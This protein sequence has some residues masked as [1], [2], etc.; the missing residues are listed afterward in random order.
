MDE[1]MKSLESTSDRS[2]QDTP[3]TLTVEHS[4]LQFSAG[5]PSG[6]TN[7]DKHVATV[8]VV[9]GNV[10][11]PDAESA[12]DTESD[13]SEE[14]TSSSG[15]T[16]SAD[17]ACTAEDDDFTTESHRISSSPPVIYSL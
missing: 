10:E 4:P 16:V 15:S 7:G 3:S 5:R 1:V 13:N 9:A 14:E 12:S 2:D 8:Q 17:D 11:S 6:E